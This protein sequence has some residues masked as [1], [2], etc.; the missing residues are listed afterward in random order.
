MRIEKKIEPKDISEQERIS[1]QN[2]KNRM[3][4]EK[5]KYHKIRILSFI[6]FMTIV[7]S[8]A[9]LFGKKLET[10]FSQPVVFVLQFLFSNQFFDVY[11]RFYRWATERRR[12]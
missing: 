1:Q 4:R 10:I 5:T 7:L 11:Q 3:E 2:Q 12:E 9:F 8:L 6:A